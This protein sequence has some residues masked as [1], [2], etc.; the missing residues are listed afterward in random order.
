MS[1]LDK[2]DK[3]TVPAHIAIIMDGNGRWAKA[4][5]L[6]R[7]E[8]HREG[9]ISVRKIVEAA[10]AA[11]INY[12]TIYA[13]STENWN[14]PEAEVNALMDLMIYAVAKETA[15]LVK[16]GVKVK[17]IGDINRLPEKTRLALQQCENDTA[18]G[19]RLTL[20]LALSYSSKWEIVN[21]AKQIAEDVKSGKISSE[22]INEAV[23]S[24][25]LS[26]RGIP[27]PDLL[28]RTG[29]EQRISNFLLWQA[30]YSE[31]YFTDTYWPDFREEQLYEAILD[32]Q[33][34]ER[35]FG[36]TSEQVQSE[37]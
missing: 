2:I 19:E 18:Q 15:D 9:V 10:S 6:D 14:R 11:H 35:R 7:S 3:N 37:N 29:G 13:F 32:Y 26:T 17:S 28:I 1:L 12:L 4:R 8:G 22:N 27:D 21:A 16:N 20:V 5:N 25:Y 23:F 31:F 36:K 24:D 33:N 30:A 34:R